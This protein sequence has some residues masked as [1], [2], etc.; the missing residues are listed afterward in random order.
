MTWL[1]EL[2]AEISRWPTSWAADIDDPGTAAEAW[3][4]KWHAR[5][6]YGEDLEIEANGDYS[7]ILGRYLA[8]LHNAAPALIA[9]IDAAD[10]LADAVADYGEL[11]TIAASAVVSNRMR[12]FRQALADMERL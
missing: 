11:R 4:G 1:D 8:R 9:A 3:T 6:P 5:T 7:A 2:K 10:A 12:A